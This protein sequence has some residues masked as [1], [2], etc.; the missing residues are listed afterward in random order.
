MAT[1]ESSEIHYPEIPS[2]HEFRRLVWAILSVLQEISNKIAV[3]QNS[4]ILDVSRIR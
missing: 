1:W 3:V 2:N 4:E